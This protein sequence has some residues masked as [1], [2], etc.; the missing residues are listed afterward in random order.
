[1]N[2][3]P[4]R[5]AFLRTW[6]PLLIG[7]ASFTALLL[8]VINQSQELDS[9][10]VSRI[11]WRF[12][13]ALFCFRI[14]S[15]V[16]NGFSLRIYALYFG[17]KLDMVEWFGLS[18]STS[19]ANI[20]TPVSGGVIARAAYLKARFKFPITHFTSMLAASYVIVFFVTAVVTQTLV[21]LYPY[22][23]GNAFWPL[24]G[25]LVLM[26]L[27]SI[28]IMLLPISSPFGQQR[29]VFRLIASILDGWGKLRSQPHL[30]IKQMLIVLINQFTQGV[31][32]LLALRALD[33]SATFWQTMM[34]TELTSTASIIRLTPGNIGLT[35]LLAGVFAQIANASSI[36]VVSAALLIRTVGLLVI[37][38]LGPF[39][40]YLLTRRLARDAKGQPD[41]GD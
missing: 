8:Y 37:L 33:Q 40:S 4:K 32:L 21:L 18:V 1:V 34:I 29:R 6:L 41:P 11:D 19:L 39:F 3:Q 16:L 13:A 2:E 10:D 26:G 14:F 23:L 7:L 28:V 31:E 30:I 36:S 9:L 5:S 35:E 17:I 38:V 22:R 20:F 15:H 25:V 27:I 12:V 24:T